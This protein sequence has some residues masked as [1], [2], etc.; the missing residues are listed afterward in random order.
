MTTSNTEQQIYD[1]EKR[2]WQAI[3][4]NDTDTMLSLTDDP[5]IVTGAQGIMKFNKAQFT[6]MVKGPQNYK[7]QN[8]EF[9][10]DYQVSVLDDNTAVI[11]YKVKE[12]LDVAGKPIQL[13]LAESSTWR[14]RN[15]KWVC[16]LHT[17][18]I[19]GDP[20]G[21]DRVHFKKVS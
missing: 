7:L 3:K 11:A 20:F 9:T 13:E 1:L 12:S 14:R 8:F 18:T 17:E 6:E 21:R 15:G 19:S 4:D 16:C 5:C 10:N 2:Y